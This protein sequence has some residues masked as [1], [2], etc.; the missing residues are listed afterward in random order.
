MYEELKAWADKWGVSYTEE[1]V[2]N[3]K[4]LSFNG[5]I[6]TDATYGE[7][8]ISLELNLKTG[9]CKWCGDMND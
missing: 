2:A 7:G 1:V 4:Y 6:Y 8:K 3:E 9:K 5:K